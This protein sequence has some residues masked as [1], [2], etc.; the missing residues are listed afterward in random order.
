MESVMTS[1]VRPRINVVPGLL[2]AILCLSSARAADAP[3]PVVERV[4]SGCHGIEGNYGW[5]QIP[6]LAGQNAVYMEAQ[7]QAYRL[8]PTPPRAE[9]PTWL[10]PPT[11]SVEGARDDRDGVT[12]M[13]GLSKAL[14]EKDGAD[15]AA[16]YASRQPAP[17]TAGDP[18]LVAQG[19]ELF[20]KGAP[21]RGIPACKGCHGP[22]GQGN[23]QFPRIAG[24]YAD[25]LQRQ[26][27]ALQIGQRT[28]FPPMAT[29]SRGLT[30]DELRAVT[31]YVQS[32]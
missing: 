20:E 12:F 23:A 16:W 10:V 25:Y 26:L 28:H 13:V 3:P 32:L 8:A 4:C 6:R 19:K 14:D 18:A 7:F 9:L 21:D 22:A 29:I 30:P 1:Y 5:R 27:R 11:P 17:G 31:E 15:A 2:A 24:Q